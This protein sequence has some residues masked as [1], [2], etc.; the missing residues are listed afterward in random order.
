MPFIV[1]SGAAVAANTESTDRDAGHIAT[2]L[3]LEKLDINLFRSCRLSKPSP[4]SR[5]VFGG[6]II[7]QSLVAASGTIDDP[8]L[9]VHSLHTYF[10]RPGDNTTPALYYVRRVRDGHSFAT[11]QV[12]VQQRGDVIFEA[13]ISFHRD[14]ISTLQFQ[15]EMPKVPLPSELLTRKDL[16]QAFLDSK[17]GQKMPKTMRTF[18][19]TRIMSPFPLD[20]R[21]CDP[22]QMFIPLAGPRRPKSPKCQIWFRVLEPLENHHAVHACATAYASDFSLV[23]TAALAGTEMFSMGASLDHSMWFHAP[24]RADEWIL[25]DISSS[26]A[27]GSRALITGR[28]FS[29]DGTLVATV[30][31]EGLL[32]YPVVESTAVPS[33]PAAKL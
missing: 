3:E 28:L 4:E 9:K 26:R 2:A 32:R 19:E 16:Y 18:L 1:S 21:Y 27:R 14:E 15:D 23:S 30:S 29:E 7:A 12:T 31:Q 6:Q 13:L 17:R 24:F 33:S 25:Y 22:K 11:R 10:V 8:A 20:M 5:A